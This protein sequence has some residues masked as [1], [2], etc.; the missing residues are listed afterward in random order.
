[1]RL[2][3]R[4]GHVRLVLLEKGLEGLRELL[5]SI[6]RDRAVQLDLDVPLVVLVYRSA[7]GHV[8][9]SSVVMGVPAVIL[10][11]PWWALRCLHGLSKVPSYNLFIIVRTTRW[12]SHPGRRGSPQLWVSEKKWTTS[13][14]ITRTSRRGRAP[15]LESRW[16]SVR[17]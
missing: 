14:A 9:S 5:R 11:T 4:V 16:D 3:L 8:I 12:F 2:P 13:W 1:V 10:A 17:T 7:A 15:C 6:R